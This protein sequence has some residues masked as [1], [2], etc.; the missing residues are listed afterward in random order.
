MALIVM[1]RGRK[2]LLA[3][4]RVTTATDVG[5]RCNVPWQSVSQWASG[6]FKPNAAS[7]ECLELNYRIP[8][9][10]WEVPFPPPRHTV[11]KYRLT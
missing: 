3:V 8:R 4:L 6:Q 5:A 2:L 10:S 9:W 1:S 7:R 11:R